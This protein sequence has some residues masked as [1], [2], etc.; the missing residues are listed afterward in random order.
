MRIRNSMTSL[1]A[2]RL[3]G[4]Q[5]RRIAKSVKRLSSG[6]KINSAADNPAAFTI[7]EK[8]RARI[9]G[10][11][12]A[13]QNSAD[14][15]SLVQTA[16]GALSSTHALLQRMRELAVQS[17]SDT[18]S[19]GEDR[20][21]LDSEYQQLV[22]ELTDIASKT[23]YNGRL[24]L[25]GSLDK[26]IY[27]AFQYAPDSIA[28]AL[29]RMA[30]L[31]GMSIRPAEMMQAGIYEILFAPS[32]DDMT[33][34]T[35]AKAAVLVLRHAITSD[36]Y[37]AAAGA[38]GGATGA[39]FK[40]GEYLLIGELG[41]VGGRLTLSADAAGRLSVTAVDGFTYKLDNN[42]VRGVLIQVGSEA[43]ETIRVSVGSAT[44]ESLGV[45]GTQ[46]GSGSAAS[47]AIGFLDT[48][49]S[50]VSQERAKLGALQRQL[51]H[52]INNLDN[53]TCNLGDAESRISDVDMA[54]EMVRLMKSQIL[55]KSASA[56]M[57]QANASAGNVLYLLASQVVS[58]RQPTPVTATKPET[59]SVTD[60]SKK[61]TARIKDAE[62]IDSTPQRTFQPAREL[63]SNITAEY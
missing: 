32:V 19:D 6:N 17:A 4:I 40:A 60:T 9:R 57:A 23:R 44:S 58:T 7:A 54:E 34:G 14:A 51:E 8:M 30:L 42:A 29:S 50:M 37:K 59:S 13:A 35:D 63:P 43:G 56:V 47:G 1:F 39:D 12:V 15:I 22:S 46:V 61:E 38:D 11:S 5:N 27:G 24:L 16:E 53:A 3:Y 49:I 26:D 62:T 33:N 41:G 36:T 2:E 45:S 28:D 10:L 48:A 52:K 55:A 31:A 18:N 25:D 21:S 20:A